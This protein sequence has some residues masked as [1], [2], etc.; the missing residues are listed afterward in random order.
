MCIPIAM[1]Q[2][3]SLFGTAIAQLPQELVVDQHMVRAKRLLAGNDFGAAL[4]E[5]DATSTACSMDVGEKSRPFGE[6]FGSELREYYERQ[7]EGGK[8]EEGS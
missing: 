7:R 2:V 4:Y 8:P 6:K 1:A 5:T 3:A